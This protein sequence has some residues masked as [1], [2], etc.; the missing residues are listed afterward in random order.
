MT[1]TLE[2]VDKLR[3]RADVSFEEAKAAL[4]QSNGDLLDALIW[5]E[6]QG[7]T[8]TTEGGFYSTR[9]TA[10]PD[11]VCTKLTDTGAAGTGGKQD[12]WNPSW[13]DFKTRMKD[14]LQRSIDNTIQA[15]RNGKV[16]LSIPVLMG[17][18]L[19]VVAFW[20]VVPLMVVGLFF[21]YRYHFA[22]PDLGK[23]AVNQVMDKVTDTAEDIKNNVKNN[24]GRDNSD[25]DGGV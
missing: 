2:Q 8:R 4:E 14:L 25:R 1:I 11:P 24:W 13:Q 22:G 6:R 9:G 16:L 3:E 18:L 5:L 12:R 21:G 10:A 20:V 23:E 19:L 7:K 15:E 17:A